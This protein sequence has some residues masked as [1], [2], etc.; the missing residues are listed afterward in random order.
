MPNQSE[1][2]KLIESARSNEKMAEW[3]AFVGMMF[4]VVALCYGAIE[5]YRKGLRVSKDKS[6]KGPTATILAVVLL[7]ACLGIVA[8][9]LFGWPGFLR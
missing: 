7:L 5:I 1:R 3:A 8:Y 9:G 6:V 2:D 4:L